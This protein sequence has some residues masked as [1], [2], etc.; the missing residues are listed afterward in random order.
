MLNISA[1]LPN[2]KSINEKFNSIDQ[3]LL[4][5][6]EDVKILKINAIYNNIPNDQL[7]T[8]HYDN[9]ATLKQQI[10]NAKTALIRDFKDSNFI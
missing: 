5:V 2:E 7:A 8:A 6:L 1:D 3:K 10:E 9:I 4:E